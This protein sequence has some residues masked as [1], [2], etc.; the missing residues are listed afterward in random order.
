[1]TLSRALSLAI[2][3][4]AA[5]GCETFQPI[6][7]DR[8]PEDNPEVRF[9]GG[10]AESGVYM[11]APWEGELLNFPG[12]MRYEL[13][14][15][16]G[17]EPRWVNLYLSFERYG[18]SDGGKLAQAA[19]NQAVVTRMDATSIHVVNDSCVPYWLL[20]TAGVGDEPAGP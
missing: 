4:L 16:L 19:G 11:S 5:T 3:M 1:M 12:G 17:A 2:I 13:V 10:A 8:D 18:T 9:T 6:T 15:G 14:H 20:V 7:C